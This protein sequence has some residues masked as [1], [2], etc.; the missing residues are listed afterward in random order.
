MFGRR[1]SNKSVKT[2]ILRAISTLYMFAGTVYLMDMLILMIIRDISKFQSVI[3]SD[4]RSK[5]IL[6]TH[7]QI[8]FQAN[9]AKILP[10]YVQT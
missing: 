2:I 1:L 5:P 6:H 10:K 3:A 8:N 4:Y 7:R 9:L